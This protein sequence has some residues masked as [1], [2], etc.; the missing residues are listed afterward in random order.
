MRLRVAW[1]EAWEAVAVKARDRAEVVTRADNGQIRVALLRMQKGANEGGEVLKSDD[2]SDGPSETEGEA[3]GVA[4]PALKPA[5][6]QVITSRPNTAEVVIV[7]PPKT[8]KEPAMATGDDQ[9][10]ESIFGHGS[11]N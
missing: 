3:E 8:G 7:R 11:A 6:R 5:R 1:R 2:G 4:S 9:V 10:S